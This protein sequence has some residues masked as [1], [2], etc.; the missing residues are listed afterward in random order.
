[1]LHFQ[2]S[3]KSK[4]KYIRRV[5]RPRPR[6]ER[7][8]SRK[9]TEIETPYRWRRIT[10]AGN[11][12]GH[13]SPIQP[14]KD[15]CGDFWEGSSRRSTPGLWAHSVPKSDSKSRGGLFARGVF[16]ATNRVANCSKRGKLGEPAGR[17]HIRLAGFRG[18]YHSQRDSN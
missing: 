11:A 18:R 10:R 12:G 4:Q 9:A 17:E 3:S 7:C 2:P 8:S 14:P 15:C 13:L 5:Q 16:R 6:D 1:M